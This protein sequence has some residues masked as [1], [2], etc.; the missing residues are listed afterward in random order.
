M[1]QTVSWIAISLGVLTA[2]VIAA[3]ERSHPQG[4]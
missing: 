4:M 1:L 2:L 3:D